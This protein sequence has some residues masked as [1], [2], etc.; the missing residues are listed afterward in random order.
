[1]KLA[2][3]AKEGLNMAA[4]VILCQ[5]VVVLC[6]IGS[7]LTCFA[8]TSGGQR[9]SALMHALNEQLT[10]IISYDKFSPPPSSRIYTYANCAAYEAMRSYRPKEYASLA[11]QLQ[12]LTPLAPCAECEQGCMDYAIAHAFIETASGLVF[13]REIF[14]ESAMEAIR[15]YLSRM[16]GQ[17]VSSSE[18]YQ[19]T[20][21]QQRAV[22]HGKRV[23][24]HF[25]EWSKAD[26]YAQRTALPRYQPKRKDP[27][28]WIT[29]PPA[30]NDALEPNWKTTRPWLLKSPGEIK[31][32]PPVPFS[33][34][35]GSAFWSEA[36][37]VYRL[38]QK[39]GSKEEEVAWFWDDNCKATEFSGHFMGMTF[40]QTPVGHWIAITKTVCDVKNVGLEQAV[41]M[42]A[43][44]STAMADAIIAT[45][46]EK[47]SSEL[48]RPV[49]YI[50]RNI[51]PAW[52]PT[53]E[54]PYFPEHPSGHGAISAAAA[55]ALAHYVGDEVTFT[56]SSTLSYGRQPMQYHSLIKAAHDAA[57]SRFYGGIHYRTG[58]Q[59]GHDLGRNVGLMNV[60]RLK[61]KTV[62]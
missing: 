51:D 10:I 3:R 45:W 11:G 6:L 36:M 34:D 57:F 13:H 14:A 23:A 50:Q 2:L 5:A 21:E 7:T 37:E 19:L 24:A 31:C 38:S 27:S 55:V 59:A 8:E 16:P 60:E 22:E 49:T 33:S 42:Y 58:C 62:D 15:P 4:R 40:K 61:L 32:A 56:D 54:T 43:R 26:G 52:M 17:P 12:G 53:L 28:K 48:V 30:Y 1:M 9:A 44:V 47:Y 18:A 29:T 35:S 25:L 39:I 20:A 46:H 41:E